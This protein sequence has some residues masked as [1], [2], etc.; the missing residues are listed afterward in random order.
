[1]NARGKH[2]RRKYGRR[3]RK[4]LAEN[5]FKMAECVEQPLPSLIETPLDDISDEEHNFF[6]RINRPIYNGFKLGM[7]L[8]PNRQC[9]ENLKFFDTNGIH[10]HFRVTHKCDF[11]DELRRESS[12]ICRT[13]LEQETKTCLEQLFALRETMVCIFLVFV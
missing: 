12:R 4:R 13:L 7:V 9:M 10:H 11:T 1:M 8:C 6:K 5:E 2:A 3:E